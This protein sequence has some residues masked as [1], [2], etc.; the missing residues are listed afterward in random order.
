MEPNVN[1][2]VRLEERVQSLEAALRECIEAFRLTREYVGGD[3]LPNVEGWSH[4]D[5]VTVAR[6]ALSPQEPTGDYVDP[7]AVEALMGIFLPT[8]PAQEPKCPRCGG[9]GDLAIGDP[10]GIVVCPSCTG[11]EMEPNVNVKVREWSGG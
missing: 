3:L 8:T 9:T 1:V 5:A 4:Y 7:N 11:G 10:P 2:R 6:A